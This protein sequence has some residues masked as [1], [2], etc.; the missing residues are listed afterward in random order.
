V[1]RCGEKV[2]GEESGKEALGYAMGCGHK[3][4][5]RV[6]GAAG[7]R[8]TDAKELKRYEQNKNLFLIKRATCSVCGAPKTTLSATAFI[9]CDYCA[10]FMDWDYRIAIDKSAGITRQE[11]YSFE[12]AV[13]K[14]KIDIASQLGKMLQGKENI[15][16][17]YGECMKQYIAEHMKS[18]PYSYSPRIA[19]QEYRKQYLEYTRL[20]Y[21]EVLLDKDLKQLL[22]EQMR[23]QN[24]I[25]WVNNKVES[26][27]FW[28]FFIA[29]N[30][31]LETTCARL[32]S[33]GILAKHP[34]YM[35]TELAYKLSLSF[36]L[37]QWLSFLY[38]ED[39]EKVLT[40]CSLV[41]EYIAAKP[42]KLDLRHCGGCGKEL[43]VLPKAQKV[44]CENCGKIIDVKQHEFPCPACSN[45]FSFPINQSHIKCA[46]CGSM[47]TS[48]PNQAG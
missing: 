7:L 29:A 40:A 17:R 3:E 6:G 41:A 23:R 14:I 19:D 8:A 38:K 37:E 9:Y 25:K 18:F 36:F 43:C 26:I 45:L 28:K 33:R 10:S 2:Q 27:S 48:L 11:R 32:E 16:N 4:R 39:L 42:V 31:Y 30:K 34:D 35:N 1:E 13:E 12:K 5:E 47:I 22:Q 24:D 21:R 20:S 15:A 46:A 44:L